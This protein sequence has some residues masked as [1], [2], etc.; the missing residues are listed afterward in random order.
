MVANFRFIRKHPALAFA[1]AGC[2]VPKSLE[3]SSVATTI[4]RSLWSVASRHHWTRFV[5]GKSSSFELLSVPHGDGAFCVCI[6]HFDESEAT[7]SSRHFVHDDVR[8]DN[9]SGLSESALKTV[10][11]RAVRQTTDIQF[12]WHVL[13][14]INTNCI[15][16]RPSPTYLNQN[17]IDLENCYDPHTIHGLRKKARKQSK[18][19]V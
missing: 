11:S 8:W 9:W 6:F 16:R 19:R 13:Y 18:Q 2:F 12:L 14:L 3:A 17:S 4:K 15:D 7:A 10:F 5:D 1:R